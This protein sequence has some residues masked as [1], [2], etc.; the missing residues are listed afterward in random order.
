MNSLHVFDVLQVVMTAAP[1]AEGSG[2]KAVLPMVV[3][4]SI[5]L[6]TYALIAFEVLHKSL[7]AMLGA[8]VAIIAALA[9]GLFNAPAGSTRPFDHVHEIIGHEVGIIGV[10]VGTSILV[11][12][13]SR[14]GLFHFVAVKIVKQTGGDAPKLFFFITVLAVLFVTFLTIAPGTLIVVSLA[15]VV[16]KSLDIDPKP[17]VMAVA[18][19]ANSGALMTLASGI[20]TLMLATASGLPYVSF[21][22]VTTPMALLSAAIAYF[23]LR[24]FYGH[25]LVSK[26]TAEERAGVVASFDEWALV[27]DRRVFYRS[28]AILVLTIVGF[29]LAGT[30]HV[31]LDFIAM[32]GGMMAL[33]FSGND[34]E[35]A[36]KMVKWP[37]I[38]FFVGLF[39][40]IGA[41]EASGLLT[42]LAGGLISLSG[43]N[44]T[45]AMLVIAVFALVTS[46]VVDNI[47]IAATLIPVVRTLQAQGI[48]PDPV[49]WALIMAANLGGNSTPVGSVSSVIALSALEKERKV[50]VGW[51]EFLKVG[52]LVTGLQGVVV[53]LYLLAF[54]K[55]NLFPTR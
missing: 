20:C 46:G 47:P 45:T 52:G 39:I 48:E 50:K 29:A 42:A 53:L 28:A 31:G 21:F 32:C 11:D 34:P 13:A 3:L 12:V 8:I 19:A 23:V 51:G 27:K 26:G 54:D 4:G 30:F 43:G 22:R 2:E 44:Q 5:M 9:F 55:L 25:L 15:L 18:I 1:A 35:D 38:L 41:V 10:L 16:T 36:I 33:F 40:V 6:V 17:Y 7:A 24:R 37:V 49:W 14:S